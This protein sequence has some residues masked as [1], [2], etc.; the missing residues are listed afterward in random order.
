MEGII[1]R[2]NKIDIIENVLEGY[3]FSEKKV[4]D[5]CKIYT[6]EN[7][8]GCGEMRCYN[9]FE[10]VQ[11]S[12]NNLNMETAYQKINPKS[13]VLEI[14]HCLEGC[15]EFKLENNERALIGK[16]D[17]SVIEIGKVPFEDSCIPTKKYVGLSIFI[18]IE[19]AQK[20]IDKYFPYAKIDLL[21]I[22]DRLCKNGAALIIHSRHE[23]DHV[24]SELYR[25]DSRIRLSYSIIK[26]IELLLFLNLVESSDTFKLTSFSEPVY[27]ATV[28]SYKT[29]LNNPFERYSI[30]DLSKKYAISESSLKRCFIY[31]TGSSIGNFIREN[32]LE[33]AAKL[34]IHK[35]L[36]SIGEISDLSGYLNPSKFSESFKKHFGQTPQ[37][38]RKKSI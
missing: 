16:G 33:D 5:E 37:E 25:V 29:I 26:T 12:Y 15:Y 11:L 6:I 7:S 13:G 9:L 4:T 28:E 32:C 22:K 2:L 10:G 19:K 31:I 3:M 38:Y 34:L 21:E 14:D 36:M 30:S 8:T 24:I 23:I 18:D 27:K 17:L 35:P 1:L 20:S